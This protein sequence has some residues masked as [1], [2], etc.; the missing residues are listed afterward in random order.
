[1]RRWDRSVAYCSVKEMLLAAQLYEKMGQVGSF[2]LCK[3]ALLAAH[4][5]GKMEQ[6]GSLL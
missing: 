4:L 2:L 6:V 5:Y 3:G 1:M